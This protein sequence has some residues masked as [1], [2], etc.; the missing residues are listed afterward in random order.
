MLDF[1]FGKKKKKVKTFT[2]KVSNKTVKVEA[3]TPSGAARKLF[4]KFPGYKTK[5]ARVISV[6]NSVNKAFRYRVSVQKK[7]A[8]IS[9]G[10]GSSSKLVTYKYRIRV[11]AIKKS[12]QSKCKS[13]KFG[14]CNTCMTCKACKQSR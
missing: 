2:G 7:S 5:G 9:Y 6:R 3:T 8:E 11:K 1:L 13:C 4:K 14:T 12:S 10:S